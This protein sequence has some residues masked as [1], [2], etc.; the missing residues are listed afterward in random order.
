MLG[1]RQ[2]GRRI[3]DTEPHRWGEFHADTHGK[4]RGDRWRC[5]FSD[6]TIQ[7]SPPLSGL[8]NN[9]FT[10]STRELILDETVF[11]SPMHFTP[12]P[13][14][15]ILEQATHFPA[16]STGEWSFENQGAPPPEP[17]KTVGREPRSR[18]KSFSGLENSPL[19]RNGLCQRTC[20]RERVPGQRSSRCHLPLRFRR[21]SRQGGARMLPSSVS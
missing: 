6:G 7:T 21:V 15:L 19:G 5:P 4:L 16:P 18:R 12:L 2:R 11:N 13:P 8:R 1:G 17:L 20:P 14:L 9:I 10:G 3:Y